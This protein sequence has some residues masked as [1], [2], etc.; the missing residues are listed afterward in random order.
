MT[1]RERQRGVRGTLEYDDALPVVQR[2]DEILAAIRDH[3]VVVICGATGS[4]KSTQIPKMCLELG[5]G[6]DGLIGHT[7]P[8][9]IAARTLAQRIAAEL[10]TDVGGTVGYKVRF[11]DR[12]GPN[13]AIKLVTDGMLLAEIQGDRQLHAYDTLIIDEAHE[14]SLNIDFLLGYLKRLLPRRPDLKVVIASA[15]IDPERFARHFDGAPILEVSGRTYPVEVRYRPLGGE[16]EDDRYENLPDA[17]VDAVHE[18]AREGRG[19]VLVF[20]SGE[21][22]IR[23]CAEALRRRHPPG[24]EILPLYARLSAAEQQRVFQPDGG[25]RRVVLA[26]NVAETS[27]TVPGIRYVVDSGLARIGRYSHRTKVTRLPIE[28]ISQASAAQRAGRCGREAPGIC[29]RLYDEDDFLGRPEFT[30]PEV[31]RTNLAAVILQMKALGLGDLDRFPFVEPPER[32]FIN[33]GFRLLHEVGAV[34]GK[35]RMTDVGR[36]L[37]RLPLD[38]PIGRILLAARERGVL[39]EVEVVAAALS[40]QDPRERPMDAQEAADTAHRRW[41]H[42]K[43]DFL[44]LLAIWRDYQ[45]QKRHLSHRKL[46]Q[47]CREHFLSPHRM[48]EWAEI[49]RQIREMVKAPRHTDL[50]GAFDDHYEP[51]HRALL[52]GLVG[53]VAQHHQRREYLGPRGIKLMIFPGSG[54]ANRNPKWIVAAELV[55][56]RRLF[57]RQVAEVKPEWIEAAAGHL[58]SRSYADPHW[59]MKAGRVV[60]LERVS[61]YG[62]DLVTGR[63]VDYGR[64]DPDAAREIFLRR[65]LVDGAFR[66]RAPFLAHNRGLVDEIE[67][68]EAK[69]RR[70]DVLVDE[71]EQYRFYDQ[72]IPAEVRDGPTFEKWWKRAGR[73]EPQRLHMTRENLVRDAAEA[74]SAEA[75]PDHLRLAG[76]ALPLEY[77]LEPGSEMDGVVARIPVAALNQLTPEPFEWL[78]PGLL[79]EK[80][81]AMIRALPKG[82]RRNF[83]PAPDFARAVLEAVS[84]GEGALTDAVTRALRRMTGV[85]IPPG[86]FHGV[87]LPEHLVMH[88]RVVDEKGETLQVGDDLAALQEGL[89]GVA[90]ERFAAPGEGGGGGDG[91]W[92]RSG[93]TAWDFGELPERVEVE[94]HGMTIPGYPML[95]DNGDAVTLALADAPAQAERESRAGVRRLFMLALPQQAKYLRRKLPELDRLRLAYRGLGSDDDLRDALVAAAFDTVFL[96]GGIP[97]DAEAFQERLEAG[98]PRLVET[99]QRLAAALLEVLA[100][101]QEIRKALK[102]FNSLALMESLQDLQEH[103]ETLVYPGFIADLDPARLEALPRYLRGVERRVE[104]LRGDPSKDRAPLRAVRPWWERWRQRSEHRRAEG[105]PPDPALERFRWLLEEYRISQFAQEIGTRE[106]VS[107][108]RLQEAWKE[109]A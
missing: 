71:E 79:H 58:V 104:K 28:P 97:R 14:R 10:K 85:E 95:Q 49:L 94:R 103:L 84:H 20:L 68:L 40:I 32:K 60:A 67:R 22:D 54:L 16:D 24:T 108:K 4:G 48:R 41:R 30:T 105:R 44:T 46:R 66:T 100:L 15:T 8:R 50:P 5:R 13:T 64:I 35:R 25:H 33:D 7:Q 87:P 55:E 39:R 21:R 23:D 86:S 29:I 61:L 92:A 56:T 19:D 31:L 57:A 90:A 72:R 69:A 73:A 59:E 101:Y 63:R 42:P 12:V 62:L 78:V 80:V 2:R 91:R 109:V 82:L 27:V 17:V 34:D 38:P 75:F 65:G 37:A 74:V 52:A 107:D 77:H 1:A 43:S 11:T 102:G 99:A 98:R 96:A 76:V 93:I 9:R 18:L 89:G 6:V 83:V 88:L 106:K 70:R 3:Q 26:T 47:W 81:T 51:I 45:E 53:S 36:E